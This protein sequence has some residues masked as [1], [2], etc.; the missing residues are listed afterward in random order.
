M[1]PLALSLAVVLAI[2]VLL[3]TPRALAPVL[4]FAE[5]AP[6]TPLPGEDDEQLPE[7]D[8]RPRTAWLG[9]TVAGVAALRIVLL[10][11]LHA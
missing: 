6:G 3:R 9:W 8:R 1:E 7:T 2:V 4:A 11:T 5:R 10:V